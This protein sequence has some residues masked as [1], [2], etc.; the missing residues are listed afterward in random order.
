[1]ALDAG[2]S[3]EIASKNTRLFNPYGPIIVVGGGDYRCEQDPHRSVDPEQ[4]I[5]LGRFLKMIDKEKPVIDIITT[6]SEEFARSTFEDYRAALMA[7]GVDKK[8]CRHVDIG[9]GVPTP[10]VFGDREVAEMCSL[11]AGQNAFHAKKVKESD[12][13]LI[14]GGHQLRL[15]AML[16]GTKYMGAMEAAQRKGKIV[17][18]TSAGAHGAPQFTVCRDDSGREFNTYPG[19]GFLRGVMVES[20]DHRD[21]R[22]GEDARIAVAAAEQNLSY[23]SLPENMAA[24][25][26]PDGTVEIIGHSNGRR[27]NGAVKDTVTVMD[28]VHNKT[29]ELRHGQ[30]YDFVAGDVFEVRHPAKDVT[31]IALYETT[32]Q[33]PHIPGATAVNLPAYV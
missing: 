29:K 1:M 26:N 31:P 12:A 2:D 21:G 15:W 22:N 24:I 10:K 8:N 33:A 18:G 30:G 16:S 32:S 25:C 3:F 14:G 28:R 13:F 4:L 6:A 7:L 11:S 19:L 23:I 27:V 17:F 20:H 5:I 9:D